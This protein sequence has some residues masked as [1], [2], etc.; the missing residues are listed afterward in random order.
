[1]DHD[2]LIN[3]VSLSPIGKQIRMTVL[4]AQKRVVLTIVLADRSELQKTSD[5]APKHGSSAPVRPMGLK[6]HPLNEELSKQ[7]GFQKTERGLLIMR[8]DADSP[9]KSD[10]EIYDVLEAVGRN[11]VTNLD[12]LNKALELNAQNESVILK[13]RQV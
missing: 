12:D 9:L 2:H 7:L 5:N 11:P 13:I 8:V 1:Q 4:R 10:V 3:L 6:L